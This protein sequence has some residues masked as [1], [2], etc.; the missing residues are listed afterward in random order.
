MKQASPHLEWTVDRWLAH[1]RDHPEDLEHARLKTPQLV[2]D[3]IAVLRARDG[4]AT[5]PHS[6]FRR[7]ACAAVGITALEIRRTRLRGEFCAPIDL[8]NLA[9]WGE[10]LL[11][12]ADPATLIQWISTAPENRHSPMR[13]WP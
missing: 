8:A 9:A 6:A 10:H 5:T 13:H 1:W 3:V 11:G 12:D 2:D 7:L 4:D